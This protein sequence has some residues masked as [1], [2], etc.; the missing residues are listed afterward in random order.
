MAH[1]LIA[2][3]LEDCSI[4]SE[5]CCWLTSIRNSTQRHLLTRRWHLSDAVI[6]MER[7]DHQRG[8]NDQNMPALLAGSAVDRIAHYR[9]R[10]EFNLKD[11][12]SLHPLLWVCL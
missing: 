1:C 12:L 3:I 8:Q 6:D 9:K 2:S 10:D 4:I 11:D 7:E 5:F